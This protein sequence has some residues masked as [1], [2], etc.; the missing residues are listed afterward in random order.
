MSKK[1]IPS[2]NTAKIKEVGVVS[3]AIRPNQSSQYGVGGLTGKQLQERF[4]LL[5][6]HTIEHL[7]EVI[8]ILNSNDVASYIS[9]GER[10]ENYGNEDR[11]SLS[12]FIKDVYTPSGGLVVESPDPTKNKESLKAILEE[13]YNFII[14]LNAYTK[15]SEY[16][17][18]DPDATLDDI[19]AKLSTLEAHNESEDSHPLII[20]ALGELLALLD[21]HTTDE[22][23]L[24]HQD[25]RDS[26]DAVEES[27]ESHKTDV[28][29]HG[30]AIDAKIS[31]H[32]TSGDAHQDIRA[33]ISEYYE[34]VVEF[35]NAVATVLD[36]D[37]ETLDQMSEIVAYIKA[38][39]DV[40][41]LITEEKVNVGDI[42]NDLNTSDKNRPLSAAMGVKLAKELT[43]LVGA[44]DILETNLG[45]T[46]ND[47]QNKMPL[48][49]N[50]SGLEKVVTISPNSS[51]VNLKIYKETHTD[52]DNYDSIPFRKSVNDANHPGTFEIGHPILDANAK[53]YSAKH[54]LTV[55]K[56]SEAFLKKVEPKDGLSR[57]YGI[58]ASGDKNTSATNGAG[59]EEVIV[60]GGVNGTETYRTIPRREAINSNSSTHPG[61]FD[62]WYPKLPGSTKETSTNET[63]M[64]NAIK[65]QLYPTNGSPM[66]PIP[67][68]MSE[69]LYAR[70]ADLKALSDTVDSILSGGSGGTG[71]YVTSEMLAA[72]LKAF[73]E[74]MD[75]KPVSVRLYVNPS[76]AE[77][78]S[79]VTSVTLSWDVTSGTAKELWLDGENV[80][81]IT[82]NQLV[83]TGSWTGRQYWKLVAE[84]E[85]GSGASNTAYLNFYN[86]VFYGCSTNAHIE[87]SSDIRSL[88][89]ELADGPIGTMDFN[90]ALGEFIYYCQPVSYGTC[91]F[92]DE[93]P[94]AGGLPYGFDD[95][96]VVYFENASGYKENY[97]VYRSSYAL[98]GT[99][100]I[101]ATRGDF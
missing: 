16:I 29:A 79:T 59:Q 25:I 2:F 50:N 24:A 68:G 3:L 64:I 63:A 11:Q 62:V 22:E 88:T 28:T 74:D 18:D 93:S 75:Y 84:D 26:V 92:K 52:G 77:K 66:H 73:K 31:T 21:S 39:R 85:K 48:I 6:K 67:I 60:S 19:F 90:A 95:P 86:G 83:K 7:N 41:E 97:Y 8:K 57:V 89:R 49:E 94:D 36:S 12:D 32:N 44:V 87:T 51:S 47:V 46:Y 37:E 40:I 13:L 76:V 69:Y 15:I 10:F 99:A 56:A 61:T 101:T 35:M 42:V 14:A 55:G 78:G 71:D 82:S 65:E 58:R 45:E 20:E 34:T 1:S 4:D 81:N 33:A 43:S 17:T 27:F 100:K 70:K 80:V 54:P 9:L 5:A 30:N 53:G 98:A 38:N 72:A 91:V 23:Q 96:W